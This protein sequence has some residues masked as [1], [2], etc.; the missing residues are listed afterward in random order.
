MVS[1]FTQCLR[2]RTCF[3]LESSLSHIPQK[4]YEQDPL[5]QAPNSILNLTTWHIITTQPI[6]IQAIEIISLLTLLFHS[7][8][9]SYYLEKPKGPPKMSHNSSNQKILQEADQDDIALA[10]SHKHIQKTH[11]HVKQLAQNIPWMLAEELKPPKRAKNSWH[12]WVE[13]NKKKEKEKESR[14]D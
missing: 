10:F 4:C 5:N 6:L 7:Y 3:I 11:L 13:Q 1:R 14:W 2:L 8:T 9:P 12:N